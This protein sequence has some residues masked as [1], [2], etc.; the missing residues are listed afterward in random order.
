RSTG[1]ATLALQGDESILVTGKN[2]SGD[3][4][5]ITAVTSLERIAAVRLEALPDPSLPSKGPGRHPSGNFQLSAFLL[6]HAMT[7]GENTPVPRGQ[8]G[9]SSDYKAQDADMAGTIDEKLG[10]VWHVWGRFGESH[11]AI[12][13]LNQPAAAG[14]DQQLVI[15]LRH[16]AYNPG[17]NLGR[18]RL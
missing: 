18:F 16:K 17:N 13:V 9:A 11:S 6:S 1:R 2:A 8:A 15:Q 4:Y 3:L 5:T 14:P 7:D 12:F 10:K